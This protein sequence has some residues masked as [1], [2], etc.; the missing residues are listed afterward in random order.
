MTMAEFATG[1]VRYC[2]NDPGEP[3]CAAIYSYAHTFNPMIA[4]ALTT[5]RSFDWD[6]DDIPT[7][8]WEFIERNLDM[9]DYSA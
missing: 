5:F 7:D 1:F 3:L 4:E 8:V 9:L 2:L 6:R